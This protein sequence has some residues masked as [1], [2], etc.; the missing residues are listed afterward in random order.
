MKILTYLLS[1]IVSWSLVFT[2]MVH[3]EAEIKNYDLKKIATTINTKSK[4]YDDMLS[5]IE[6]QDPDKSLQLKAVIEKEELDKVAMPKIS[7]VKNAVA[8]EHSSEKVFITMMNSDEMRIKYNEKEVTLPIEIKFEELTAALKKLTSSE[9]SVTLMELAIP[10]AHAEIVMVTI[11][12]L[13]VAISMIAGVSGAIYTGITMSNLNKLVDE[14]IIFCE[15]PLLKTLNSAD[16]AKL[17]KMN[18]VLRNYKTNRAV[19]K[20]YHGVI[21]RVLQSCEALE[22]RVS[23]R[24]D[25]TSK[26]TVKGQ[27]PISTP[28]SVVKKDA[29][30]AK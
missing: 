26:T 29:T 30:V 16:E 24:I 2:P 9:A 25:G 28:A 19:P 10:S 6:E 8:I 1:T 12:V 4:S 17:I 27:Q 13:A 5:L 3:A 11:I 18:E 14:R 15:N 20:S 21:D 23:S 22:Q 7:F